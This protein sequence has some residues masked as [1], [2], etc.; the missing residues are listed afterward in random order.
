MC[1][2]GGPKK[3]EKQGAHNFSPGG[4]TKVVR[5]PGGAHNLCAP[6]RAVNRAANRAANQAVRHDL[7]DLQAANRA[8]RHDFPDLHA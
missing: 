5:P 4:R 6:N 8:V 2:P 1:A 7:A 3:L